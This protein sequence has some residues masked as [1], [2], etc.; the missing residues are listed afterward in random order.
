[1]GWGGALR[2]GK[3]ATAAEGWSTVVVDV[4]HVVW[5]MRLSTPE[6]PKA[7]PW[8]ALAV[9]AR[10]GMSIGPKGMLKSSNALEW[11]MVD[12]FKNPQLIKEV[13]AEFKERKGNSKYV[14]MIPPG[15]PP[16][17]QKK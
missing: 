17:P 12:L 1:M 10:T 14:P 11:N 2:A 4:S 9:V 16:V 3:A 5:G 6:A 7:A 15:P 13:K 8:H